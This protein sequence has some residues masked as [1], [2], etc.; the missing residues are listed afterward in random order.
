MSGAAMVGQPMSSIRTSGVEVT[1][2][3]NIASAWWIE[4]PNPVK[5]SRS[6]VTEPRCLPV[7]CR[8]PE[9]E[10]DHHNLDDMPGRY[11]GPEDAKPL[12]EEG[13]LL[14]KQVLHELEE[15]LGAMAA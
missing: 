8:L 3:S 1:T 13:R 14:L 15:Q 4:D 6:D 7:G 9:F 11:D 12:L 2:R 10:P 5:S